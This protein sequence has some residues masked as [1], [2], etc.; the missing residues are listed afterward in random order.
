MYVYSDNTECN[1]YA[2]C[3]YGDVEGGTRTPTNLI[4][5]LRKHVLTRY[6]K[7]PI[8]LVKFQFNLQLALLYATR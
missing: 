5:Q 7:K 6:K 1:N 3:K 4:I 2:L 8:N